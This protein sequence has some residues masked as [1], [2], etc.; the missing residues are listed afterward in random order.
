M[1]ELILGAVISATP[2]NLEQLAVKTI[3]TAQTEKPVELTL[4]EKI[5]QNFYKCDTNIQWI[6]ADDATCLPKPTYTPQKAVSTSKTIVRGSG[7]GY[8]AGYCTAFAWSMRPDLPGN[9]G[10]A[11][12]WTTRASAQGYATGYIPRAG[13]IGQQGMHVAYVTSVNAD[14]TFNVSEQNYKGWNIISS[15]SNVSP[16]GWRFI[17]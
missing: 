9:L 3:E 13:A 14:G 10:N 11:N 15:R 1:I 8:S 7:G 2:I 17:Y 16:I 4:Q 5:D 12:T 6:R